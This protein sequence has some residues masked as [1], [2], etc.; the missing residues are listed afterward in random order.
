VCPDCQ[1]AEERDDAARRVIVE[2]E[3]EVE[4]R[5]SQSLPSDP[6]EAALIAYA[7]A[8]RS[9]AAGAGGE[10][11]IDDPGAAE[12]GADEGR[13]RADP[14][15][16]RE[17][18]DRADEL[19]LGVA[20]TGAFLTGHPLAVPLDRYDDVQRALRRSLKGPQWRTEGL[21]EKGGT[22]ESGGGFREAVPLVIARREGA[23]L[24]PY[25]SAALEG[26]R[27]DDA[28]ELSQWAPG[29]R[30]AP[31]KMH[32]DVYDVG[33][34]VITAWFDVVAPSGTA[35]ATARVLREL[36]RLR[37]D[38]AR[39]SPLAAE[40]QRLACDLAKEY[41]DAVKSQARTEQQVVWLGRSKAAW[42]PDDRGRLLW[43]HPI[44]VR[45]MPSPTRE[46]A[47]E[48]APAFC[49]TIPLDYGVFAPGI[50]WSAIVVSSRSGAA[51]SPIRLTEVHWAYYA[52]FMEIDRGLLGVLNQQRWVEEAPLRELEK[53]AEDVFADYLRVMD[54]R[55]RLDS[56]LDALGGDEL[57]MWDVIAKV[58]RF[59]TLLDAVDRKLDVLQ[60]LAQRRVEQAQA[61]RARRTANALAFLSSLTLVSLAV[62]FIGGFLGSHSPQIVPWWGRLAIV[63]G[64]ALIAACYWLVLVR[65]RPFA[66]VRR[67]R[68]LP[69]SNGQGER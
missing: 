62:A 20:V 17:P 3:R 61:D 68:G 59:D 54:A 12:T 64:A 23:D 53:D 58:Q 38:R 2:I 6:Y 8:S 29:L 42:P 22:F 67:R 63:V 7:M 52:L 11:S 51:D 26:W 19:R 66:S 45:R 13:A 14:E 15:I 39:L 41:G 25:L 57:A 33:V 5:R 49:K 10:A 4:R 1:S 28:D 21:R 36:V 9:A 56:A 34:A 65:T 46:A 18:T 24:V 50:G 27:G 40:L 35:A 55:A 37:E 44:H 16:S 48:L 31:G 32:I 60:K 47:L 69:S 43:L 30:V